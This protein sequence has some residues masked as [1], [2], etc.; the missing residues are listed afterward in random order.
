M[1]AT[2]DNN[3]D[4]HTKDLCLRAVLCGHFFSMPLKWFHKRKKLVILLFFLLLK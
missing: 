1:V 3:D 2:A 4:D